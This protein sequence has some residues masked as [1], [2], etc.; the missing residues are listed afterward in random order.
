[1]LKANFD[2]SYA[3]NRAPYAVPFHSPYLAS[4][5]NLQQMKKFV[6]E[7]PCGGSG[8]PAAMLA[9]LQRNPE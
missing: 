1:M 7:L 4:G 8:A 6:G 9:Q 3:G 2:A 5:D